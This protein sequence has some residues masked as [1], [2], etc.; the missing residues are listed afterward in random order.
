MSGSVQSSIHDKLVD[1]FAPA[2][3]Q[4]LNESHMHSVPKNSETHFK[5]VVVSE[6]FAAT[7]LVK[8]HRMVNEVLA[9]ELQGPVHALSILAYTPDQW[10]DRGEVIPSSPPC[11]GGSKA[12]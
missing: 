4:V 5:V 2:A 6:K 7:P 12:G 3:L 10:R 9:E 8:R 11:R 1:A